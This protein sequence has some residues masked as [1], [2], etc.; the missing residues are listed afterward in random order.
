[1]SKRLLSFLLAAAMLLSAL[2]LAVFAKPSEILFGDVN[3]DGEIDLNDVLMLR[4][5][6][7]EENPSGFRFENADVNADTEADMT[8]LLMIK[9]YLA[10]WDIQLGPEL[11]TVTF[12]D[13]DRAFD[14]LQASCGY[15][16]GEVPSVTKSSKANATLEGYYVDPE[17]TTPFYAENPVTENM[18]VYAKYTDMA[19]TV[20]VTPAS[21]AQLDQE[22]E[23]SFE[24]RRASGELSP[25]DAVVLLPKD[26]S[27]PVAFTVTD[28][29]NDGV[30]T[31]KSP[32]GFRRGC[33]YELTLA[34]G[35]CFDGKDESIRTAAFSIAKDAVDNITMGS[36]TH[37]VQHSDPASLRAGS[38]VILAGITAGDLICFYRDTNPSDRDYTGG[39]A[40]LDDPE[41]WFRAESVTGNTVT[42]ADLD[43]SD[44][45]KMYEIPDNFPVSG[46]LPTADSGKLTLARDNDAFTLDTAVYAL[47]MGEENGTLSYA[48]SRIN[49][50]DFL[51]IYVSQD[52]INSRDDIFFARITA[53]DPASGVVTYERCTA[54]DIE[55]SADMYIKPVVSGDDL[56]SEEAKAEIESAVYR[57][58]QNS[59]FAEEA[60]NVLADMA[61]QTDG[62][63]NLANATVSITDEN[64]NALPGNAAGLRNIGTSF[65]LKD[66]VTLTVEL[67]T[68][69]DQMHFTDRG[70][71]QL[72]V[73]IDA[74]F[75]VEVEDGGKLMI[76]LSATFVQEIALGVTANGELV[77]TDLL[78]FIPVP[79]GVKVGASVD[80]KSFTGIRIDAQAYTEQEED[81]G[82][83]DQLKSFVRNPK[84][85][86]DLLPD[87]LGKLKKGLNTAGDVL[88]KIDELRG[89]WEQVK[90]DA[91]KAKEY[92]DDI[93]ALWGVLEQIDGMPNEAEWNELGEKLGK[94]NIS[95]DLMEMMNL[96]YETELD[97]DRYLEGMNGLMDKYSEMLEKE[98][99]WV[100]LVDQE[101][102]KKDIYVNGLVIS[103]SA[104]FVVRADMN[105][106]MGASLQQE[107]GK[108]YTFWV[109]FGLFRPS[110]GSETM[111]LIDEQFAFQY[112]VMGKMGLKAGIK[113]SLGFA[114]GCK[115][116]AG[117]SVSLEFGP[118]VKL[119]G[120]FIYDYERSRQANTS[121]FV[122]TQR[123]GGAVYMDF[124]VYLI[125][126]LEAEAVGGMFE[127]SCD[128]V[129]KEYPLL[130]AG[131][132]YFPYEFTYD[133]DTA[134][135]VRIVDED[136]DSSNGITMR[137]PSKY[138]NL[139][140]MNL[141]TGQRLEKCYNLSMYNFTFSNPN[142]SMQSVGIN[143]YAEI[144]VNVPEGTR[145]L[146]CDMTVTYKGSKL[147]FNDYDMQVTIPLYWTNLTEEEQTEYTASIRLGNETD[148][149]ETV[150]SHQ[151]HKGEEFTLP[152]LDEL[153][154]LIG[155][156][157]A[158]FA[159]I[160][161]PQAGKTVSL[162]EDTDYFC[163]ADYKSYT[164]TVGGVQNADG[165]VTSRVFTAHYGEAFDFSS[166]TGTGYDLPNADAARARFTKF[167]NVTTNAT[168]QVGTDRFG[169]P[170]YETVDLTQPVTGKT[171]QAIADGLV[172]AVANY[173]DDSV[174]VTYHFTGISVPDHTERLRRG[175]VSAF[176]FGSVAAENGMA[177][178][179]ISPEQG[180]LTASVTYRVECCEI[181]G[182]S[183]TL[184]FVENG[185]STV[186]D[187]ERVGGSLVGAL[188]TPTRAGYTFAGWFTDSALRT[189]FTA[190]L[191]PK[192]NVTLY[193]KWEAITVTVTLDVNNGKEWTAPESGTR[194]IVYGTVYGEL[195]K[196]SRI[197][198]GFVGWF[199]EKDGGTQVTESTPMTALTAHTLYAHWRLLVTIDGEGMFTVDP[200][201]ETY[202][203]TEKSP[204]YGNIPTGIAERPLTL[205]DF[206]I[207][208]LM[209][210]DDTYISGEPVNAGTYDVVI[211]RPADDYYAAFETS[212]TAV[213]KI[214][215]A[216]FNYTDELKM[217]D[218]T[219]ENPELCHVRLSI[220]E[221][222]WA[223]LMPDREHTVITYSSENVRTFPSARIGETMYVQ[224]MNYSEWKSSYY[225]LGVSV[226]NPNYIIKN[227][228]G[229]Q[230]SA[231]TLSLSYGINISAPTSYVSTSV[232]EEFTVENNAFTITTPGQLA[233]LQ[234]VIWRG[235]KG[236]NEPEIT[237]TLGN[238]LDMTGYRWNAIGDRYSFRATFDGAGHT[239]K[240][241]Y[242]TTY[243]ESGSAGLFETVSGTVKN[244]NIEESF[245]YVNGYNVRYGDDYD[246]AGAIAGTLIDGTIENC[247]VDAIVR[248]GQKSILGG[249]VGTVLSGT[250]K[251][252]SVKGVIYGDSNA[253]I[254]GIAGHTPAGEIIGCTVNAYVSGNSNA[255]LG[256][257]IGVAGKDPMYFSSSSNGQVTVSGC[258][259]RGSIV[260]SSYGDNGSLIGYLSTPTWTLEDNTV[261][262][263]APENEIGT[264]KSGK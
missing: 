128:L 185:G 264:N 111:D 178:K 64:G 50:G 131:D 79:I 68:S 17:F 77:K 124:G 243:D 73:G 200:I 51:S 12:Y 230:L 143:P 23:L 15:P 116:V 94:T 35:W 245:F 254:G 208:Y 99:D 168:V 46:A 154:A 114:V 198:Y 121:H 29:D 163:T 130:K 92:A 249:I 260:E 27:D 192:E 84:D 188:P 2:P 113:G 45:E 89:K 90:N 182:E 6:I 199:T 190:R 28:E 37:F 258:T 74:Q 33:S 40:Y 4:R 18:K 102:C 75:E 120:F 183:F 263:D 60:A 220:N 71:V 201:T 97:A 228:D 159:G 101:I 195:P 250:V 239:I 52:S 93:T 109:K 85:V 164:V 234:T 22:P 140:C 189:P 209:Q 96:S 127:A 237:Y 126:S 256:G 227:A 104:N 42:L 133:P 91:E 251:N 167:V 150:W 13:G 174:L 248:G 262:G 240:G 137:L 14:V 166:L 218:F 235:T 196:P 180:I 118:Y 21:F 107:I 238:D 148:G 62:F 103:L 146:S 26:G 223:K 95:A 139:N 231:I 54:E 172:S 76:D 119:Y 41:T 123:M 215:K 78:G 30:Y 49:V 165:S 43:D 194:D 55:A 10:E 179:S 82:L 129:D 155:Y 83:L 171:A 63:R 241:L 160:D 138:R 157:D 173:A 246:S 261:D 181:Q 216:V 161:F 87:S 221:E 259:V 229:F 7:A 106:S 141:V 105:I 177:V 147:A 207:R 205:S 72:A 169:N 226:T 24:I 47:M 186:A 206:T 1:M 38:A 125:V 69:G 142:F 145:Y 132:R 88:D 70:A 65:E 204:V 61:V 255:C 153:K 19:S 20:D 203:G 222:A 115:D 197:G 151:A 81:E 31:V 184:S 80:I 9:K 149:Y 152:T 210:G 176:D 214:E 53:Y 117:V 39:N 57:Q 162:A 66:G 122:S 3:G 212:R 193:A 257:I 59:G 252:C 135:P 156:S 217:A 253:Y 144:T 100:K 224:P 247:H 11:L 213:V 8:D 5:Y 136:R 236:Y 225:K 134:E 112:Y 175:S 191:M 98:T 242:C 36:R 44:V 16:L 32:D 211:S 25:Q 48:N 86:A 158:K 67:I 34:D 232:E 202:D 56:I 187:I 219:Y 110:A 170:I 58:V 108:R 244:L 233:Y